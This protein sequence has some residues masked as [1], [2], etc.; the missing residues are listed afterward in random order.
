V[1][2][3]KSGWERSMAAVAEMYRETKKHDI[4]FSAFLFRMMPDNVTDAMYSDI[5]RIADEQG[6]PFF[7]TLPWFNGVDNR[8]VINSFIDSHP[9]AEGHRIIAEGILRSLDESGVLCD[10]AD[11]KDVPACNKK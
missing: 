5:S 7:D 4:K 1:P 11:S 8:S 10:L 6:F 3:D 9:N 2:K